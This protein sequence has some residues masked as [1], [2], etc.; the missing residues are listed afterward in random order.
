MKCQIL[1]SGKSKKNTANLSS[2]ELVKREIE[3]KFTVY[4]NRI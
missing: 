2:A 4:G 1:F 3:V